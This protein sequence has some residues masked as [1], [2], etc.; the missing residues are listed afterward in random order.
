[1]IAGLEL[2]L[3]LPL[4]RFTLKVSWHSRQR[5]LGVFGHSGAG[6]TSLLEVLAGLRRAGSGRITAG[7]SAW[8]DTQRGVDLPPELRGIGYVPQDALLFPHKDVMGNVRFGA[9]RASPDA[10]AP[11]VEKVME[12]LELEPLRDQDTGSLSGGERQ[13]VAL[14][15]ALCSAPRWLLLDEPLGGLDP[16][17]RRRILPYLLRV[18]EEFG[19]PTIHVSHDA[20][21]VQMLCDE[22][23]VLEQGQALACGPPAEV[24]TRPDLLPLARAEGFENVL[25]G[26]V[27]SLA[28]GS[29]TV[30]LA[31][32]GVSPGILVPAAG[33][34]QGRRVLVSLRAEDIILAGSAPAGLSAQNVLPAT[35]RQLHDTDGAVALAAALAPGLPPVIATLTH[36][37]VSQLRLGPGS[38]VFLIFKAQA[39]RVTTS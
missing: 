14:A 5:F 3:S 18:R 33:L 39:C 29:A 35:V 34:V 16:P 10:P 15:R 28:D 31:S 1:V 20:T 17:L 36:Q 26:T 24:L 19:I 2:D 25:R 27:T 4:R 30:T 8:L 11:A 7:G 6:K 38:D 32:S 13:R 9:R 21:E 37:A 23:L 12:V 22:V